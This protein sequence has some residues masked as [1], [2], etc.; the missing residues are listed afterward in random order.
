MKNKIIQGITLTVFSALIISFV[1]FR[2]GY[3]GGLKST[4]PV[5]PNGS[6]LNNQTDAKNDST[7]N[8]EMIPSSKVIILRDHP[9]PIELDDSNDVKEV[10]PDVKI[11]SS[12]MINPIIHSSK[13]GIILNPRDLESMKQDTVETDSL[14]E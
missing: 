8:M 11:D 7:E 3:F 2:S 5:S 4:Y 9:V 14:E 6:A 10:D 12:V 13:S 1:A